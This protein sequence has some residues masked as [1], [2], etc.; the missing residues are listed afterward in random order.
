M[1]AENVIELYD[2]FEKSGIRIR[3]DGGWSVDALLGEQTRLHDDLDIVVEKKDVKKLRGILLERGYKDIQ[4][5]DTS[6]FN[7][8]LGDVVGNLIDV[9]V[10]VLDKNGNGLYGPVKKGVMYPAGA[11]TGNGNIKNR[12]V[13]CISPE[14]LVKFHT[15]YNIDEKDI[16]DVTAI[17]KRFNIPYPKEYKNQF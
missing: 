17:C 5:D 13:R 4:R 9:H 16:R 8:V 7:F 1:K 6:I 10:I 12:S 11:L 3:L 2:L 15:G 14:Y